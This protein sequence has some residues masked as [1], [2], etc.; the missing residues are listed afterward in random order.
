MTL[1]WCSIFFICEAIRE[2]KKIK[3][4]S[5]ECINIHYHFWAMMMGPWKTIHK[6]MPIIYFCVWLTIL[7]HWGWAMCLQVSKLGH[8]WFRWWLAIAQCQVIIHTDAWLLLA[9]Q[10]ETCFSKIWFKIS[11]LWYKKINLKMSS[12]K[13]GPCC[14][15]LDDE[16]LMS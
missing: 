11:L 2:N 15:S 3:W 13:W 6:A 7:N 10:L 14:P 9:R 16:M 1:I 4:N 8:Y 12:M 5:N